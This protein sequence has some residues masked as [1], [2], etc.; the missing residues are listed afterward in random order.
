[1]PRTNVAVEPGSM[2]TAG[3]AGPVLVADA[4]ADTRD[5]Y[6]L[7]LAA[8]GVP[9]IFAADGRDALVQ[10]YRVMPAA[11][12]VDL[13]LP[14]ID[15]PQLC[16]LLRN[17]PATAA[18]RIVVVTGDPTR[19]PWILTRGAD[20]VLIKP[21]PLD[22][23]IAAVRRESDAVERRVGRPASENERMGRKRVAKVRAHERYVTRQPPLLPPPLKCPLCDI[24]LQ[25]DRSHVGGV[26]DRHPEQ[27]DS[28][29]CATHGVFQYRHRT[30]KLRRMP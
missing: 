2:P 12:V 5:M 10:I 21:L 1:M 13:T 3:V 14:F 28:F 27:W 29:V 16:A 22:A 4:S 8:S 7:A 6:G 24:S 30:R 26:S 17:D 11:I 18:L 25:Y 20:E 19:A 23:L 15:A 9:V